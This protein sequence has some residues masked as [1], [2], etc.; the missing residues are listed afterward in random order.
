MLQ[1]IM[2]TSITTTPPYHV[3]S[4]YSMLH[5]IRRGRS[6]S[7]VSIDLRMTMTLMTLRFGRF[8][9]DFQIFSLVSN[10]YYSKIIIIVI[11]VII[12]FI[13]IIIII[14]LSYTRKLILIDANRCK[15]IET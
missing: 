14:N 2:E 15:S 4:Y 3:K 5:L 9:D 12:I 8:S 1:L 6:P 7:G 11:I 10:D 13:I